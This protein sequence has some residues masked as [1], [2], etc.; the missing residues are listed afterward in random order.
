MNCIRQQAAGNSARFRTTIISVFV[1]L[2]AILIAATPASAA[3]SNASLKGVF[4]YYHGHEVYL[5]N[6]VV[7]Q[8]TA[9]GKGNVSGSWTWSWYG[10]VTAGTFTGTYSI[11]EN[12]TGSLTF[13]D[14]EGSPEDF[15]IVLDNAHKGFQ[16]IVSDSGSTQPGFGVELGTATCGLT[17]KKQTF[18][19]NL[20]G[21]LVESDEPEAV[22]GQIVL[23]GKGNIS[24][25]ETFSVNNNIS[26][27]SV[28]GTYTQSS[29]CIGTAQ[30][31]PEGSSA[32]NFYTV[33]VN[34][35]KELLLLETDN[36]SFLTGNAQE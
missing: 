29:D 3:C 15:Y 18:A 2:L 14:E 34:S 8:F 27:V 1:F 16:M 21:I 30:I 17:G 20:A 24:G 19:T 25:T 31:T 6:Y 35:G 4:G 28:T 36:N 26:T 9:D 11:A 13:S 5:G 32:T 7:G 33:A 22:V 10:A 23:D 12:C